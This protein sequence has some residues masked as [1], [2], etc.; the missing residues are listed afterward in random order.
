MM[1]IITSLLPLALQIISMFLKNNESKKEAREA[2]L[3][4]IQKMQNN[5]GESARLR[6]SYKA[7]IERLKKADP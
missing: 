4:F 6:S 7:Q 1:T 3:V 2:F 5:S